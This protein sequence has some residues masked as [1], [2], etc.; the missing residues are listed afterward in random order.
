[1]LI[2]L[3]LKAESG[4]VLVIKNLFESHQI[5]CKKDETNTLAHIVP[6]TKMSVGDKVA[7][8]LTFTESTQAK[9]PNLVRKDTIQKNLLHAVS[10]HCTHEVREAILS[11]G[12]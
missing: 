5:Q 9:E 7:D 2:F 3:W 8:H 10:S 4:L 12:K 1:M 11:R 6:H